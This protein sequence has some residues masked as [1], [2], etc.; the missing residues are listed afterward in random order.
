MNLITYIKNKNLIMK[1]IG[2]IKSMSLSDYDSGWSWKDENNNTVAD[3]N[4]LLYYAEFNHL[5]KLEIPEA[6]DI[7]KIDDVDFTFDKEIIFSADFKGFNS[8]DLNCSYPLRQVKVSDLSENNEIK[9]LRFTNLD[10]E[11]IDLPFEN[12]KCRNLNFSKCKNLKHIPSF[13]F[14][15]LYLSY[16]S[17]PK[18]I[19][20][21]ANAFYKLKV[22]KL[23]YYTFDEVKTGGLANLSLD[24]FKTVKFDYNSTLQEECFGNKIETLYLTVSKQYYTSQLQIFLDGCRKHICKNHRVKLTREERKSS[25]ELFSYYLDN[26]F[27][28][29]EDSVDEQ[30]MALL[31]MD[32]KINIKNI[33]LIPRGNILAIHHY[34][35]NNTCEVEKETHLKQFLLCASKFFWFTED[36]ELERNVYIS[37]ISNNTGEYILLYSSKVT[38]KGMVN[39]YIDTSLESDFNSKFKSKTKK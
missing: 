2:K 11:F 25:L 37:N 13:A 27:L 38:N 26:P 6:V 10:K 16:L 33:K 23:D 1:N 14:T 28:M 9:N 5:E 4:L 36:K 24:T 21:E 15:D 3:F 30:E 8:A 35:F 20:V 31:D 39:L 19:S 22:D 7:L 29:E 18:Y 34:L 12:L 32:I 17:L